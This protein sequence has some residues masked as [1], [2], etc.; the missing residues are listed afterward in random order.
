MYALSPS[1][2]ST[3]ARTR[4][5]RR[6]SGSTRTSRSA[7]RSG[8]S[9]GTTALPLGLPGYDRRYTDV[10][11]TLYD[12]ESP[13]MVRKLVDSLDKADYL[14]LA[15]NRLY[16]SIP[17]PAAALP[18]RHRVLPA[19][20]S[21]AGLG[22]EEVAR[23]D[24]NPEILGI[25]I[26]STT[27]P[28]RTSPST[29][30][31]RCR[32]SRSRRVTPAPD[33]ATLLGAVPLDQIERT[34]PV[35]AGQ[36]KGL[37]LTPAEQARVA[38]ERHLGRQLHARRPDDS[39]GGSDLAARAGASGAGRIPALLAAAAR[40]WPTAA[41]A[42]RPRPRAGAGQLPRLAGRQHRCWRRSGA[43]LV[44]ASPAAGRGRRRRCLALARVAAGRPARASG[45]AW[46]PSR[47]CSWPRWR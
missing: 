42:R 9:T 13:E 41:T 26:D 39:P 43:A 22:F 23:F 5:S 19:R 16:G 4:V 10:Q 38:S 2:R 36:R 34:K 46:S 3:V 1:W 40:A 33:V 6:Q 12:D 17:A 25:T 45:G 18:R 30:T 11:M 28:R 29:T 20:C 47:W 37:M 7:P 32:S 27:A 21:T 31:R 15:S 8:W 44:F 24:S 14:I 35:E